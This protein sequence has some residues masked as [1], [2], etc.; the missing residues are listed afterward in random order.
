MK[1]KLTANQRRILEFL[2]SSTEEL[3]AQS[4]HQALRQQKQRVGL[5][6]IYRALKALQS[7]GKVQARPLANGEYIY[8][9][10][11]AHRH[12]FTC[13]NCGNSL[14]LQECPVHELEQQLTQT[15]QFQVFYHTLEFFGLCR[16]C[17]QVN[18]AT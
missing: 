11:S 14:P 2:L 7:M 13:V 3:S 5:A 12:H 8:S 4:L 9:I 16:N 10:A 1:E 15:Q 6:T 18:A 17:T